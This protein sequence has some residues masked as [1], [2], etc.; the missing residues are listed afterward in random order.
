MAIRL[1]VPGG[2]YQ[3]A[4]LEHIAGAVDILLNKDEK[5]I[6]LI[7]ENPCDQTEYYAKCIFRAIAKNPKK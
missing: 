6:E 5:F 4:V 3:R 7:V 2:M 1:S